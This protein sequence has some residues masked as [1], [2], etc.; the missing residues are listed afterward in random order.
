MRPSSSSSK[1]CFVARLLSMTKNRG[2]IVVALV[3]AVFTGSWAAVEWKNVEGGS[4]IEAALYNWMPMGASKVLGLRP[5]KEAVPLLGA[6]IQKQP[7]P[8]LYSLRAMNE[9]AA[10]DFTRAE[11][12]WKKYAE[13]ATDHAAGQLALADFYHR[14]LRPADEI[15]VLT[16]IGKMPQPANEELRPTPEQSSWRAFERVL[17]VAQ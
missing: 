3:I 17:T 1:G 10:L 13:S 9:E 5:P 6:L 2:A 11:A 4:A 14:R 12:D 7:T 8:E 16:V 15:A